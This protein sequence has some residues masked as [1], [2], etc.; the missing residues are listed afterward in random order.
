MHKFVRML[1][2]GLLALGLVI[3]GQ[4]ATITIT[5]VAEAN[6]IVTN[7]IPITATLNLEEAT[8]GFSI[9]AG[10]AIVPGTRSVI[11][12][13]VAAA[14]GGASDFITLTAGA[15]AGGLQPILLFFQ[16]DTAAGFLGNLANLVPGTPHVTE[17]GGFQDVSA[18]L[19]APAGSG[20]TI[21]V[22]S[23]ILEVPE[24]GTLLFIGLGLLATAFYSRKTRCS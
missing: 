5:D 10:T 1:S 18:L 19:G 7:D 15:P 8:I 6:P 2:T 12:D 4:A 21:M 23:D 17:T 13:E 9:P 20:L 16:S 22:Q 24:P 14:G 11:F 3:S